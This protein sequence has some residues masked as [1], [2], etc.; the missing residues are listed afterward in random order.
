MPELPTYTASGQVRSGP[1]ASEI[2]ASVLDAPARATVGLGHAIVGA[3]QDVSEIA[4]RRQTQID[5]Q[6]ATEMAHAYDRKISERQLEDQQKP[7]ESEGANFKEYADSLLAEMQKGA[8]SSRAANVFRDHALGAANH[9]YKQAL[10]SGERTRLENANL[11]NAKSA[12]DMIET[13]KNTLNFDTPEG[14]AMDLAS[15]VKLQLA[16]IQESFGKSE[17]ILADRMRHHLIE[18]VATGSAWTNPDFARQVVKTAPITEQAKFQLNNRIDA[19]EKDAMATGTFN[20]V[21]A[22]ENSIAVGYDKLRPVPTPNAEILKALPKNTADRIVHETKVANYT[23]DT[24]SKIRGWNW[25]EQQKE[26]NGISIEGNPVAQD[27]RENLAKMLA[28]SKQQQTENPAGWQLANNPEFSTVPKEETK[29]QQ[30]VRLERMVSLQGPPP[31]KTSPDQQKRYLNLPTGL[32]KVFPVEQAIPRAAA[33]NNTPPNQLTAMVDQFNAEWPNSKLA[34]MAWNDMQNLPE[35]QR[36]RMG[37]RVAAAIEDPQV[38]NHFLGV[39]SNKEVLK[40][41][42]SKTVFETQMTGNQD[43]QKFVSGWIGDSGQRGAELH[44]FSDSVLRYAMHLSSTEG[45]K[46]AKAMDKAVKRVITDNYGMMNIHG[47]TVPVY[48]YPKGGQ[49][50]ADDAVKAI[51]EGIIDSINSLSVDQIQTDL[52]HFPLQ[53]RLPGDPKEA[54]TY[55]RRTIQST[56]TVAVEPDGVSATIYVKGEGANDFP[57]QL[58]GADGMPFTLDFENMMTRGVIL[59]RNRQQELEKRIKTSRSEEHMRQTEEEIQRYRNP[60]RY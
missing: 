37:I 36:L 49:V 9:G 53:P 20:L 13:Y 2:D 21:K 44:E 51:Q 31:E 41:E 42:D 40:T 18:E 38:R 39:M 12:S 24:F 46:T 25:Q 26:L 22:F 14:A 56:G 60:N 50:Y 29:G 58:R 10:M 6:W 33:F 52:F 43:Y 15:S 28:K 30:M 4:A 19:I 34:A 57:F 3:G 7:S 55:M 54:N 11:S 47:S 1:V 59:Q 45:L 17:P 32:Q 27:A 35:S 48:R 8:P 5:L 23:I 16:Y